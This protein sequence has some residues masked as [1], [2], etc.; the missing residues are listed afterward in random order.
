M[1]ANNEKIGIV[2]NDLVFSVDAFGDIEVF[3]AETEQ[4]EHLN[5]FFNTTYFLD[6]D[7]A[8]A[9]SYELSCMYYSWLC[10]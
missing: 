8:E 10:S 9:Q 5:R 3:R 2:E 6:K 1:K 4:L 7:K